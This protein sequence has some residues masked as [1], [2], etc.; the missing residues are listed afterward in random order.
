MR[1]R[2]STFN[3]TICQ[4]TD[5]FSYWMGRNRC[6][7]KIYSRLWF[8]FLYFILMNKTRVI[9]SKQFQVRYWFPLLAS[10]GHLETTANRICGVNLAAGLL[11]ETIWIAK[12]FAIPVVI[13]RSFWEQL[14][15]RSI[16]EA[17]GLLLWNAR[18]WIHGWAGAVSFH[19]L[20]WTVESRSRGFVVIRRLVS[21]V[22]C[23]GCGLDVLIAFVTARWAIFIAVY[24]NNGNWLIHVN[25]NLKFIK[26]NL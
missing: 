13:A 6:K 9:N 11:E 24:A 26:K 20:A 12:T 3:S 7:F 15:A 1:I 18:N 5:L 8:P 22:T 10:R 19:T 23:A 16:V 14:F 25:G 2:L 17:S 21:C 4:N